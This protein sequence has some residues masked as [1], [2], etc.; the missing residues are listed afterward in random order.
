MMIREKIVMLL[1]TFTITCVT[2]T[3]EIV[4]KEVYE[5]MTA[6][7]CV[8]DGIT[9]VIEITHITVNCSDHAICK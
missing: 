9:L 6:H 8:Y 1:M 3:R 4:H 7:D 5:M 2:I